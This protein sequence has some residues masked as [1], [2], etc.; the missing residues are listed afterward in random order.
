MPE[1]LRHYGFKIERG[2]RIPCHIHGGKNANIGIKEQYCHC[3]KCGYSADVIKF[4][5]DYFGLGF[6]DAVSKI[7]EDFGLGLPIGEQISKRQRTDMARAV[8]LRKR[9]QRQKEEE[10]EKYLTA[11]LDAHG[12]LL[13]LFMQKVEFRPKSESEQLHPK[14]IEALVKIEGAKYRLG[15]AEEDLYYYEKS[16]G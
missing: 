5:Q 10:R 8:F 12:E 1:L 4:V 6:A 13:R 3:F 15:C 11:W 2:N 9:E 16:N 14:F 7:N